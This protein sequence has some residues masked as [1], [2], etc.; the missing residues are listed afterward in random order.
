MAYPFGT[1]P[2]ITEDPKAQ[3]L[4]R[5]G[6]QFGPG[7]PG[8]MS[9][10]GFGGFG[11][12]AQFSQFQRAGFGGGLPGG[13]GRIQQAPG[14]V[15]GQLQNMNNQY[16]WQKT[17][18]LMGAAD[19]QRQN[20]WKQEETRRRWQQDDAGNARAWEL[21]K[22]GV[23]G[24]DGKPRP[25]T[26]DE[27]AAARASGGG[28][29]PAGA[30]PPSPRPTYDSSGRDSSGM[31]S[32]NAY[33]EQQKRQ[34]PIGQVQTAQPEM[35][36]QDVI[37]W[38]GKTDQDT[39][40]L[41]AIAQRNGVSTIPALMGGPNGMAVTPQQA[42]AI[43]E[44]R[45]YK[46]RMGAV[47]DVQRVQQ[48]N[49]Q[50]LAGQGATNADIVAYD[51]QR[52]DTQYGFDKDRNHP[53]FG[54]QQTSTPPQQGV[55]GMLWAQQHAQDA[56]A[57]LQRSNPVPSVGQALGD[58][59]GDYRDAM[60]Q[61][62]VIGGSREPVGGWTPENLA[63]ASRG[64]DPAAASAGAA[65]ANMPEE[66]RRQIAAEYMA[67]QKY[68][69]PTAMAGSP[70]AWDPNH[71]TPSPTGAPGGIT[72]AQV[73]AYAAGRSGLEQ[74]QKNLPYSVR[75]PG[76][77]PI[78]TQQ[79]APDVQNRQVAMRQ[80]MEM[81]S[82]GLNPVQILEQAHQ[83]GNTHLAAVATEA[84]QRAGRYTGEQ[85]GPMGQAFAGTWLGNMGGPKAGEA[86]PMPS[87]Y[88][89]QQT[90]PAAT[91]GAAGGF[92]AA[93]PYNPSQTLTEL[94]IDQARANMAKMKQGTPE[95]NKAI[96]E[97]VG[98]IAAPKFDSPL[99]GQPN[100]PANIRTAHNQVIA[101]LG[102]QPTPELKRAAAAKIKAQ[103]WY[104]KLNSDIDALS[105]IPWYQKLP[106]PGQTASHYELGVGQADE[107]GAQYAQMLRGLRDTVEQAAK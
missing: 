87:Q 30:V 3:W 81:Q 23:M 79:M 13:F 84:L 59:M 55:N 61:L 16:D 64:M 106:I 1:Q 48:N 94:Q 65:F 103:P 14:A 50:T 85:P 43:N 51:Q 89:P 75:G 9:P 93:R 63:I 52:F 2:D 92:M 37:T 90:P 39:A 44:A 25:A 26:S 20:A 68:G 70:P 40:M 19:L 6:G 47:G 42:A 82:R 95:E 32:P 49:Q 83:T 54:V 101:L 72:D 60:G 56:Q 12:S 107:E 38:S 105:D 21:Q 97:A 80:A 100:T 7:G 41:R 69:M 31:L 11:Q 76:G 15:Q 71:P 34:R 36:L 102:S 29:P 5:Q 33:S 91:G 53:G 104:V 99:F 22:N 62:K 86:T 88:Q 45:Q 57:A 78:Q 35:P 27:L 74:M 17:G 8:G 96:D 46:A 28:M 18:A 66:Q 77:E 24:P 58:R 4:Q 10:P 67:R 73:S 98:K